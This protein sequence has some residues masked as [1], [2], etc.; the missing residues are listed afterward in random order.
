MYEGGYVLTPKTDIFLVKPG[1]SQHTKADPDAISDRHLDALNRV[2]STPFAVNTFILDVVREAVAY[3]HS[4]GGIIPKLNQMPIPP[5]TD[6]AI[7][8]KMSNEQRAKIKG[9]IADIHQQNASNVGKASS[10]LRQIDI[11]TQMSKHEAHWYPHAFDFRYRMY[12]LPSDISPQADDLGRALLHFAKGKR[13]G[14]IGLY[15]LAVRMATTAGQDKLPFIERVAWTYDHHEDILRCAHDPFKHQWW[16]EMDEPW[17]FLATANEWREAHHSKVPEDFIS[18]LPVPMDG[19]INGCQ[20]LSLLGRD[21][22]GANATNCTSNP[23]RQDLYIEVMED[24]KRQVAEDA[25]NGIPEAH[26][27]VGHITRKTVKRATMTT[28]YGVTARGITNQLLKDRMV[29]EDVEIKH[30]AAIYMQ[31]KITKALETVVSKGKELMG[32]FQDTAHALASANQPMVWTIP[33]GSRVTQSYRIPRGIQIQTLVGRFKH[34]DGERG[35]TLSPRK[36]ALA[37]APNVI[38]S[39]DAAMLAETI[40]R[41]W[42]MDGLSDFQ[43][44]HDSYAVHACDT[45]TLHRRIREVAYDQYKGN[46]LAEFHQEQLN[47]APPG[48]DLPDPPSLGSFDV[49]EVMKAEYFFS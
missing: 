40:N 4:L 5:K 37:A 22:V 46:W 15:W 16:T 13:L 14:E 48:V 10:L 24:V 12:P 26:Q 29:P 23:E 21:P 11:A 36:C 7:W 2:Q 42:E 45:S 25:A 28:P 31:T 44:I 39:L 9:D 34:V 32:Y 30:Q 33:T 38:H 47:A 49:S 43:M 6:D 3:D 35:D 27:W 17:N 18:H 8:E 19:S 20:H 1:F 41:L